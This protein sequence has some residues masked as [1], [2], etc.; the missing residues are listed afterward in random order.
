MNGI[1]GHNAEVKSIV[2]REKDHLA[3]VTSGHA[4]FC[5]YVRNPITTTAAIAHFLNSAHDPH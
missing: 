2:V 1:F 5:Y 3:K 4:S